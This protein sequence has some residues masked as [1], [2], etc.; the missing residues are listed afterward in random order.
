MIICLTLLCGY[1]KAQTRGG[2]SSSPLPKEI[3][4]ELFDKAVELIKEFE[5]WHS[6]KHY[7]YI[8]YGHKLLPHENLTA[9]ITEAQADSLLRADLLE[10]YKY[11]RLYGKDALLLTVLAYN[12]GHSRLLGYGK[13]P[14]SNLIKKIESGDRDF[15]EEYISYRCYK[16]KPIP[17]I[18]RRRKREFQ[19]LY[20]P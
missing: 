12:V 19:L 16:G 4:A 20:I 3:S 15:Y 17:S 18:E 9:D 5:G 8:G 7:P 13:R 6:A 10:R 11:F 1:A 14:K 2:D